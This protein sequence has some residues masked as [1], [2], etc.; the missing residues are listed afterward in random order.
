ML[1][2]RYA[3]L[4]GA[5]RAL[6]VTDPG[7]VQA[8]WAGEVTESLVD[9]GIEFELFDAVVPN[10]RAEGVTEGAQVYRETGCNTIVAVGGGSPIDCAKGIGIVVANGGDILDF[11]GVDRVKSPIPPL[12]CVP[13]TGGTSADVSQFSIITDDARRV[14]IA[15]ISKIVVPDVALVDP[16]TLTTMDAKLTACT[17]LDALTHAI[18]A[19]VSNASSSV[20]DLHALRAVHLVTENLLPCLAAPDDLGLRSRIMEGSL[21]F[22]NASLGAVHAMAHSL[23]GLLDLPH[24]ECNALLLEHVIAYNHDAAAE[25][26]RRIADVMELHNGGTPHAEADRAV[27]TAVRD[28]RERAGVGHTLRDIGVGQTDVEGLAHNALQDACMATNPR[29]PDRRDI[30]AIYEAAL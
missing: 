11:E 29:R 20:T 7:V 28:L 27:S 18:E 22:S 19:Y 6:I 23:G 2:G 16:M 13:T 3:R 4:A 21:A 8:G 26:Y 1:A 5:K 9:E 25:R 30:E 12:I 10:P 24:G 17:G 14:K 15:I